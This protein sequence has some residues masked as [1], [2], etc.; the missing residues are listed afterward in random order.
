MKTLVILSHPSANDSTT[1]QFFLRGAQ[2][3]SD[4]TWHYLEEAYPDGQ[5]DVEQEQTLLAEHDRIIFQFPMY[6]YSTPAFLKQWQD[7]V[8]NSDYLARW[9]D[10]EF[11]IVVMMGVKEQAFRAG[12]REQFQLDELLRPYQAIAHHFNWTYLPVFPVYQFA[13]LSEDAQM[14]LLIAYQ[15]YLTL[16]HNATIRERSLWLEQ[17]LS[18]CFQ[19]EDDYAD[20]VKRAQLRLA[21]NREQLDEL[22]ETLAMFQGGL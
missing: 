3:L 16:T 13:Y 11:G 22:H 20:V 7:Q 15:Q 21:A 18:D 10:K 17:H 19:A 8:L 4:V 14:K 6:W 1:Q 9:A 5:I 12:G 2:A